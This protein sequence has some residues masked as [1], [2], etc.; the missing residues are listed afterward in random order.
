MEVKSI[1]DRYSLALK[2]Y[3]LGSDQNFS[4][5]CIELGQIHFLGEGHKQ[6]KLKGL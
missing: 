5:A 1:P 4:R 3:Q 6:N 2:Y